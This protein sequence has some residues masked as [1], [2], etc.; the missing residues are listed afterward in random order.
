MTWGEIIWT[1]GYSIALKWLSLFSGH[2]LVAG[3]VNGYISV[4][5]H[6]LA[7]DVTGLVL[8]YHSFYFLSASWMLA[9]AAKLV[10]VVVLVVYSAH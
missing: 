4:C 6:Q 3:P 7:Y 8:G 9:G 2:W 1:L 5:I 10:S